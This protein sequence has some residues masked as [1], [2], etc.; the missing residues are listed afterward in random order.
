VRQGRRDLLGRLLLGDVD[1]GRP[2]DYFSGREP[3]EQQGVAVGGEDRGGPERQV[4]AVEAGADG[5]L[6]SDGEASAD[7]GEHLRRGG[8]RERQGALG[9]A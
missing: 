6:R 7:V 3:L 2:R 9:A 4:F 5:A 1:D 8:G